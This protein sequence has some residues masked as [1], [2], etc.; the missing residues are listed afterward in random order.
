M[1]KKIKIL[2]FHPHSNIGGADLSIANLINSLSSKYYDFHFICLKKS[3]IKE[4]LKKK[5][6][7]HIIKKSKVLLSIFDIRKIIKNNSNLDQ[8]VLFISNQYFANIISSISLTGIKNIKKI[9]LER[10]HLDELKNYE[11]IMDFFKK[12]IIQFSLKFFYKRAEIIICN[13]S[14]AAYDLKRKISLNVKYIYN[15]TYDKNKFLKYKKNFNKSNK[16]IINVARFEKQKDHL[17]LLKSFKKIYTQ[18]NYNLV[19]IGY[20]SEEHSI[21]KYIKK[22]C[23]QKKIRI[24]KTSKNT[25]KYIKNAEL[26]ILTSLYEGLPN[27]LIESI[28]LHT[29]VI[30]ADCNSGPREILLNGKGGYLFKKKD[31]N[32]LARKIMTYYKNPSNL[33]KKTSFAHTKLF[34]FDR[35]IISKKFHQIF[36]SL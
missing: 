27:V 7:I 30:S 12:K 11:N 28:A 1:H 2:F 29:P 23:L 5:I 9:F 13:S 6:K 14:K 22:Y 4:Y 33:K 36:M 25:M 20:G 3:K 16:Y 18:T 15:P 21:R 26:F 17:T 10:N 31:H 24:I 8:K 19:L 32:S 35:R 34:R